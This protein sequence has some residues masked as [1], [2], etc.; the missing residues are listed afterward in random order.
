MEALDEEVAA[1]AMEEL[2]PKMQVD[3]VT[4]MDSDR[5]ADI[6]QE[7]NP[8]AAA[9]LLGDPGQV[10]GCGEHPDDRVRR[11]GAEGRERQQGAQHAKQ[12]DV[13]LHVSSS[14]VLLQIV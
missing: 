4:N 2:D 12:A 10:I 3:L 1:E 9:D 5:A 6:V 13:E 7:M 14:L 11:P 8:D